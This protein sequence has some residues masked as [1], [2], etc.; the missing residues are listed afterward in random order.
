M[1]F[2]LVPLLL[3]VTVLYHAWRGDLPRYLHV[4]HEEY[5]D[6]VRY[7]PNLVSIRHCDVWEDIYGFQK[8]VTKYD[9]TYSPFRL[10]PDFTST[11]NTTNVDVHKSRRR[12]LNK[13]FSEQSIDDYSTLIMVQA[14][15]FM[16]QMFD[17]LPK[18]KDAMTPPVNFAYKSDVVA[19]EIITSLVSGQTYGFQSGDKKSTSLLD[20]IRKFERKLYLL[21]FAPWL[22]V[23]PSFKPAPELVQWIIQ[24]SSKGLSSESKKTLVAKMLAA[25][26]ETKESQFSRN[27]VIADARFFLLGGELESVE[28]TGTEYSSTFLG[29]VTSSSAL[30]ATLFFLLH[31]P[32]EM[33]KL[34]DELKEAFPA[35][36]SIK[37]SGHLMRCKRL[38]AVFE[39]SMRLAPPVPTLLP[40]LVGPGGIQACGKYISEGI[41]VGA[42]C[43]AISR[44]KRCFDDPNAF[45]PDRWLADTS[46]P[47]ASEKLALATKAS[48][49]FSYGPRA[50]PGRALAF[51]ENG[52]LLARLVYAFEMESVRDRSIVEMPLLDGL[53]FNQLDT[54]GVHE[55]ELM[56]RYKLRMGI[57]M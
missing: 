8:N 31:H 29:S 26:D 37:A 42:P 44:D 57:E 3:A 6:F 12:L 50:C 17:R 27:D 54:V 23:L 11:W 39:E 9:A 48:Q 34:H 2:V 56:V 38:R 15:E 30:S 45:K 21:G 25:R 18:D 4:L 16:R 24:S 33:Q 36:E 41:V 49:P 32:D 43:W 20:N 13:L 52:L 10:A 40:R 47:I 28:V 5:G 19:R 53:V 22:K 35:Y 55:V 1:A 14:D 51:R 7:A 46:D